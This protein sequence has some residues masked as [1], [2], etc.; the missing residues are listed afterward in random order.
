MIILMPIKQK[1][2]LL[3]LIMLGLTEVGSTQDLF[4]IPKDKDSLESFVKSR[5]KTGKK[6]WVYYKAVKELSQKVMFKDRRQAIWYLEEADRLAKAY[7]DTVEMAAVSHLLGVTYRHFGYIYMA[8]E[9]FQQSY[10]LTERLGRRE[11]AAW[12]LLSIGNLYFDLKKWDEANVYYIHALAGFKK[13][14]EISGVAVAYNNMALIFQE[15]DRYD[16][17]HYYFAEAMNIRRMQKDSIL[18]AHSMSY[19][20]FLNLEMGEHEKALSYANQALFRF[21][22]PKFYTVPHYDLVH[23][24]LSLHYHL[25]LIYEGLS[26]RDS[27][28]HYFKAAIEMGRDNPKLTEYFLSS[29]RALAMLKVNEGKQKEAIAILEDALS[30]TPGLHFTNEQEA[31]LLLISNLL[32]GEGNYISAAHYLREYQE[33]LKN[34]ALGASNQMLNFHALYQTYEQKSALQEQQLLLEKERF[35]RKQQRLFNQMIAVGLMIT[36]G[37]LLFVLLLY[38]RIQKINT[39]LA[40]RNTAIEAQK[41]IIESNAKELEQLNEAKDLLFSIIAHDLRSPFNTLINFSKLMQTY[42]VNN[43]WDDLKNSFKILDESAQKAYWT[44]ENLLGWVQSQTGKLKANQQDVDIRELLEE[45]L[46]LLRSMT[47]LKHIKIENKI[48]QPFILADTYMLETVLRNILTNAIKFSKEG[49]I[50]IVETKKDADI[51]TIIIT[52]NGIGMSEDALKGIFDVSKLR[53]TSQ[54]VSGL[55]L[56]ICKNFVETMGGDIYV[57]SKKDFGTSFFI[58]LPEGKTPAAVKEPRKLHNVISAEEKN[59]E[60]EKSKNSKITSEKDALLI[61]SRLAPFIDILR[62]VSVYEASRVRL[63]I[64]EIRQIPNL[65]KEVDKWLSNLN[66]AVYLGDSESFD[67]LMSSIHD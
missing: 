50:I 40:L 29:F 56:M 43:Q 19:L 66:E 65:E 55:G 25:G 22:N 57:E 67:K 58:R 53:A 6:D 64:Q 37:G 14:G 33:I 9:Y 49:G 44:F 36:L 51:T 63:L 54:S 48:T 31:I 34:K 11:Y 23:M 2:I 42:I 13:I 12:D 41:N 59:S 20:A 60:H 15:K 27:A 39:T 32:E 16:S 4:A 28:I 61:K 5:N 46:G 18:I 38:R 24:P 7:R 62:E 47:T 52:D 45:N 35:E 1:Y 21:N 26:K 8:A 3:I 10:L 30:Y 17:A